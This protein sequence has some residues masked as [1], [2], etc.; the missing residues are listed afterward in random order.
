MSNDYLNIAG[1]SAGEVSRDIAAFLS[2]T[3]P[4]HGRKEMDLANLLP[5][6]N[7]KEQF[8][9]ALMMEAK[10]QGWEPS[11][12]EQFYRRF[13][14]PA[15]G[16]EIAEPLLAAFRNP[17]GEEFLIYQTKYGCEFQ[18]DSRA[19]W[20]SCLAVAMDANAIPSLMDYFRSFLFTVME[21]AYMDNRNPDSVY[22]WKYYESFQ[23]ILEELTRPQVTIQPPK[24]RSLGGSAGKRDADGYLLALGVDIQN[25]NPGHMATNLQV[26]ITLKDKEGKVI[27]V[28]ADQILAIDADSV[29]HYGI[30][31]KIRGN[32]VAHISASVKAGQFL[33]AKEQVMKGLK[34]TKISINRNTQPEQ[35]LG[36]LKNTYAQA[37]K[38]FALHYQYLTAENKILGGGCE[39]VFDLLPANGEKQ[40]TVK[41][42]VSLKKA[43]KIVYSVDF[44]PKELK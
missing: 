39:W 43:T 42:P 41:A 13:C 22:V 31:R 5:E 17:T 27:T 2:I 8:S 26:D 40:F 12:A 24:V 14:L 20:N 21:F 11:A 3:C 4:V 35:L 16:A 9:F 1:K 28:I 25:P 19:Y 6:L 44:D 33:P 23:Q 32:P 29:F 15:V 38:S 10:A 18:L 34:M 30:T 36:V 7:M 37:L